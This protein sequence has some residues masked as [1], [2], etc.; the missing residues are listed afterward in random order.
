MDK[1]TKTLKKFITCASITALGT[2][3]VWFAESDCID[4]FSIY[5]G[6][7]FFV[8]FMIVVMF[9]TEEVKKEVMKDYK[10]SII[11]G[12]LS[13]LYI[14]SW[15]IIW[16]QLV[17]HGHFYTGLFGVLSLFGGLLIIEMIKQ[18]YKKRELINNG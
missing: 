15:F 12:I 6:V 13:K 11:R 14:A 8:N 4:L 18:E 7:C 10:P 2:Y 1:Y 17:L 9:N 16:G 3:G 5:A